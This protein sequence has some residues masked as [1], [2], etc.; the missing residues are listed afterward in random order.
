MPTI[1]NEAGFRFMIYVHD[2]APAHIHV[3]GHGGVVEL[4]IEPLSL[5]AVRGNLTDA[6]VR[7]V[8]QIAAS[9]QGELLQ[10][11]REHHG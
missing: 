10:A 11:W 2:H 3:L 8:V 1:F 9:R 5:R 4:L 6:Q 7:K